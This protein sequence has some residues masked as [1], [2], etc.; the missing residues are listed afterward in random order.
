M[1]NKVFKDQIDRNLKVYVDDILIKS[2][3]LEKHL[4]NLEEN[5]N[6]KKVNKVRINFTKCTFGVVARKFLGF[7]LIERGIEVNPTNCRAILEM[8]SLATLK[9]VQRLNSRITALSHFMSRS[10]E[11]CIPFYSILKKDK[12]FT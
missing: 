3:T 10:V 12:T 1:M 11:K 8:R 4:V 6:V 9:E 7:M 2:K 5:F